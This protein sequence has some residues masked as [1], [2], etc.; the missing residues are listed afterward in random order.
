VNPAVTT[1][2]T[3]T[4]TDSNGIK[5]VVDVTV[6]DHFNV[7]SQFREADFTV[8][9][10]TSFSITAYAVQGAEIANVKEAANVFFPLS[11]TN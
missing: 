6:F 11:A 4:T 10:R 5:S 8:A 3:V 9:A 1:A 7:G 2:G